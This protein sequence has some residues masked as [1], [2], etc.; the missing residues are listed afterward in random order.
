[1][2]LRKGNRQ[3]GKRGDMWNWR[4]TKSLNLYKQLTSLSSAPLC[5]PFKIFS[6]GASNQY[7]SA[8]VCHAHASLRSLLFFFFY[9]SFLKHSLKMQWSAI[10]YSPAHNRR[11]SLELNSY[12]CEMYQKLKI[13]DPDWMCTSVS[14]RH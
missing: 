9:K 1:M 12:A 5:C 13:V 10:T 14:Q 11:M 7:R 3:K 8:T 4:R 6:S 2:C